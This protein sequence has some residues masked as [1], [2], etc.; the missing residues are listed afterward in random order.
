MSSDAAAAPLGHSQVL[1]GLW[2]SAAE[3]RLAH[4][5]AFGP[6]VGPAR[7]RPAAPPAAGGRISDAIGWQV[8]VAGETQAVLPPRAR[9]AHQR[10]RPLGAD[11]A[12]VLQE[13][14]A[15]C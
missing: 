2:R 13:F 1:A 5:L 15:G 3:G 12:A 9:T 11:T 14:G 4:A 6:A 10:A 8:F 7:V